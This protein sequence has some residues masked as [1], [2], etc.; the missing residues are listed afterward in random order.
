MKYC[1]FIKPES[2]KNHQL[3][4]ITHTVNLFDS[5]LAAAT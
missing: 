5:A 4:P 3:K 1:V 2:Y